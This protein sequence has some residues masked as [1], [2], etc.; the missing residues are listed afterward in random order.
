M[1][2]FKKILNKIS[3]QKTQASVSDPCCEA[4][5]KLGFIHHVRFMLQHQGKL[6]AE[7]FPIFRAAIIT[8]WSQ[9]ISGYCDCIGGPVTTPNQQAC[10]R[11]IQRFIKDAV[12]PK[13]NTPRDPFFNKF[14]YDY[15]KHLRHSFTHVFKSLAI[16]IADYD[17]GFDLEGS[18]DIDFLNNFCEYRRTISP[19]V[20]KEVTDGM[21]EL[22]AYDPKLREIEERLFQGVPMIEGVEEAQ[23][24][25]CEVSAE[26]DSVKGWAA[27][28]AVSAATA[29]AAIALYRITRGRSAKS[30]TPSGKTKGVRILSGLLCGAAAGGATQ[31]APSQETCDAVAEQI[32]NDE[33]SPNPSICEPPSG[34][35]GSQ[36][37]G[38][39][40]EPPSGGGGGVMG[41]DGLL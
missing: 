24:A 3:F 21:F 27:A 7:Q 11:K 33:C 17:H 15:Y 41:G 2:N 25:D 40:V 22:S 10:L 34:G 5:D 13:E 37:P 4:A 30:C 35:G 8:R 28:L 12:V 38:G 9:I 14:E 19:N 29:A 18:N 32:I 26:N 23:V 6:R 16:Q 1:Q 39:G 31:N 20:L 36:P